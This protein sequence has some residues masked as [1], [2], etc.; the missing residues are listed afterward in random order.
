VSRLLQ[1][2]GRRLDALLLQDAAFQSADRLPGL[3]PRVP[4][5]EDLRLIILKERGSEAKRKW[6]IPWTLRS[7]KGLW[8]ICG[9]VNTFI[10]F[11]G[12]MQKPKNSMQ[13]GH[14]DQVI[15]GIKTVKQ[16]IAYLIPAARAGHWWTMS[17]F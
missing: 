12:K 10:G 9:E 3:T 7:E 15:E 16:T 5:W 14:G 2:R 11:L 4:N 6:R 8:K 13:N 17:F 1:I